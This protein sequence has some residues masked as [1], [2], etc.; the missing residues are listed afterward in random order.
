[1]EVNKIDDTNKPLE[2]RD[3]RHMRIDT[4]FCLYYPEAACKAPETCFRICADCPRMTQ[5]TKQNVVRSLFDHIKSF[6]ISLLERMNIQLP[7]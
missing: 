5:Y 6:S 3:I 4:R 2:A 7:K 1:M